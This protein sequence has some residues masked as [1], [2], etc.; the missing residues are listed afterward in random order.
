MIPAIP[1]GD[2]NDLFLGFL[3]AVVAPIDM[4]ARR[5]EMDHS[6]GKPQALGAVAARRL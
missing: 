4:K 2:V 1:S 6:G 3:V 5:V